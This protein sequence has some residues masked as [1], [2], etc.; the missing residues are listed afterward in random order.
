MKSLSDQLQAEAKQKAQ[1]AYEQQKEKLDAKLQQEKEEQERAAVRDM[2]RVRS[3]LEE[4]SRK[5]ADIEAKQL[6]H[7]EAQKRAEEIQA[8]KD[9]Y[10][11]VVSDEGLED[12][13]LLR[14]VQSQIR[15]KDSVDKVIYETYYRPAY[16][17]LMSHLFS[18][19]AKTCGIY[20]IT[21]LET[22]QAYIGQSV[23]IK[24]RFKTH[25]KTA[26]SCGPSTNK[27][28]QEMKK[29]GPENFSFEILEEVSRDK[30][31]EREVYWIDFYKTKDF[32]MNGTRGGAAGQ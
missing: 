21:N 20:K 12:V 29:Y 16:D 28:Y 11:L 22:D 26:L 8:Q 10:R 13:R 1:N 14:T 9:Y 23:D 15:K 24:E 19:V 17:I 6:A 5:L 32:G 25:I 2:E 18:S 3:R 31:N 30:L 27:L 7:L 4:E